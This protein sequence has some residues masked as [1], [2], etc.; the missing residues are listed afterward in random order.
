MSRCLLHMEKTGTEAFGFALIP[1]FSGVEVCWHPL[2]GWEESLI[3]SCSSILFVV[4]VCYLRWECAYRMCRA[5]MPGDEES[6]TDEA[7][8]ETLPVRFCE[9][10][11]VYSKTYQTYCYE[12]VFFKS[13]SCSVSVWQFSPKKIGMLLLKF[14]FNCTTCPQC[15][16]L[17]WNQTLRFLI[18]SI[19]SFPQKEKFRNWIFSVMITPVSKGRWK[20]SAL[21][22]NFIIC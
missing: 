13:S 15:R 10:N 17:A 3:G 21:P 1:P 6:L 7:I 18:T 8:W 11:F 9:T 14:F 2:N 19:I 12:F 4:F 22:I 16:G 20:F 5:L